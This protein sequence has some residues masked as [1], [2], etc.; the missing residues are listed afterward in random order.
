MSGQSVNLDGF[1]AE[2]M[3]AECDDRDRRS[4]VRRVKA[5]GVPRHKWLGDFDFD[6][7]PNLKPST[8]NT[9]ATTVSPIR[10]V[11]P[12]LADPGP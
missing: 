8:I 7:N 6:A 9:L 4:S 11:S 1:L 12:R 5:A 2:L 3:L 10:A